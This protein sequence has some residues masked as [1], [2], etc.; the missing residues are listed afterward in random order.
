MSRGLKATRLLPLVSC[1]SV[2]KLQV[3]EWPGLNYRNSSL[4]SQPLPWSVTSSHLLACS[5]VFL[6]GKACHCALQS[7][8]VTAAE[9]TLVRAMFECVGYMRHF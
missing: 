1:L 8:E 3:L 2:S 5:A 4:Q 7:C 9:W 6:A